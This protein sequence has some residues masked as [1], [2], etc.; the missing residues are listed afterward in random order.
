M[1]TTGILAAATA[2]LAFASTRAVLGRQV[3]HVAER[4]QYL[5]AGAKVFI[6]G[7]GLG[8]RFN[9]D[10]IHENPMI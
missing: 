7:L 2:A 6:D 5:V 8:R 9:N 3:P 1:K 4:R 10:D